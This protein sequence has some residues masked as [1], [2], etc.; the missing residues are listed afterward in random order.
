MLQM[1]RAIS[2]ATAHRYH[3]SEIESISAF[4][5]AREKIRRYINYVRSVEASARDVSYADYLTGFD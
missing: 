2:A 1:I 4:F 5:Q 3:L